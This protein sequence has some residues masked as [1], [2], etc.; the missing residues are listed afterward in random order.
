[1]N[2]LLL[3]DQLPLLQIQRELKYA[4]TGLLRNLVDQ[5]WLAH[6]PSCCKDLAHVLTRLETSVTKQG[7]DLQHLFRLTQLT[8]LGLRGRGGLVRI[9]HSIE[10]GHLQQPVYLQTLHLRRFDCVPSALV[11][12][13]S[14]RALDLEDYWTVEEITQGCDLSCGTQLTSISFR[15]YLPPD[16][17]I[18]LGEGLAVFTLPSGSD[19]QLECLKIVNDDLSSPYTQLVNLGSASK[20]KHL[21]LEGT[22]PPASFVWPDSL[23]NLTCLEGLKLRCVPPLGWKQY[24]TL[25]VLTLNNMSYP[26]LPTWFSELTHLKVLGLREARLKH[27]PLCLMHLSQ[28][29]SLDLS[30]IGG[31]GFLCPPELRSPMRLSKSI[32]QFAEWPFLTKLDF[33]WK[34]NWVK[35]FGRSKA[36]GWNWDLQNYSDMS[37]FWLSQLQQVL[38]HRSSLL[39]LDETE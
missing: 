24:S 19:V 25:Q 26:H 31:V 3:L 22:M 17:D 29:H 11:R 18:V 32:V 8:S 21:R 37:N 10:Q 38:G 14:L 13:S 20:L 35:R 27:F 36:C 4:S 2:N 28:L 39:W 1:M 34:S 5:D 7:L 30:L 15:R 6:S 9:V 12:L 16:D 23:L 33:R